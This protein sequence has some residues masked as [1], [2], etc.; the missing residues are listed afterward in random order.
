MPTILVS[1]FILLFILISPLLPIMLFGTS[2]LSK[3]K[4]TIGIVVC[5]ILYPLISALL[6]LIMILFGLSFAC[7][8]DKY[9]YHHGLNDPII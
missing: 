6:L 9:E 3:Q 4:K 1:L 5:I 7:V 8:K 2:D